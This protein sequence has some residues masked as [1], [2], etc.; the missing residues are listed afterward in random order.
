M[1]LNT[2]SI[3]EKSKDSTEQKTETGA[4]MEGMLITKQEKKKRNLWSNTH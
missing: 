4:P 3:D 1:F 2:L